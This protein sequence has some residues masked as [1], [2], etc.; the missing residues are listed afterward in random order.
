MEYFEIVDLQGNPTGKV[1][2]REII[3]ARGLW[4]QTVHVWVYRPGGDILL[5]KRSLCKD[6]HPGLWDVSA[7]GH[8]AV[9][10]T[11]LQGALRESREELGLVIPPD[12]L[13]FMEK[14]RRTL[15]SREGT[16]IDNEFTSVYIFRFTGEEGDLTPDPQEVETIGFFS[17]DRLRSLLG[18]GVRRAGFV[19]YD[20]SYY[21]S[22]IDR[23]DR[24]A[25]GG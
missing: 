1:Q 3:H 8:V 2:E 4:H 18:N 16:F 7:A 24:W 17:C 10:E 22:I 12:R 20:V 13:H 9:G 14:T 6:S 5:Q 11:A 19:P 23:V 21:H 15:V 25:P